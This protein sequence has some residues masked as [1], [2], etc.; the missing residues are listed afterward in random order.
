MSLLVWL[1]LIGD[2]KNRGVSSCN[3]KDNGV[4]LTE[5]GGKINNKCYYLNGK[6]LSK[7]NFSELVDVPN[8]S[9][10]CWVKF[11][12]FPSAGSNAYCIC[13][14]TTSAS[15]YK[16]CLGVYSASGSDGTKA[17][18]RLNGNDSTGDIYLNQWYHLAATVSG[19]VG[20]IYINGK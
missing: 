11:T 18:V 2:L 10:C 17:H 14:N 5:T 15:S 16:I 9:V 20:N 6:T 4:T 12:S 8:F 13:L 1:P 19:T 3:F 7:P